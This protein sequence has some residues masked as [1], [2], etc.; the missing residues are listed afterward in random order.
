MTPDIL[1]Q[2]HVGNLSFSFKT[3]ESGAGI[4]EAISSIRKIMRTHGVE[5]ASLTSKAK[6]KDL[7][8]SPIA[9]PPLTLSEL[10]ISHELADGIAQNIRKVSYWN[11]VLTILYH[12]S[13]A[14][15]YDDIMSISGELRKPVS[16][17]WLNTE[18]QR[19]KYA[20]LVRSEPMPGSNKRKYS[21]TEPGR[22]RAEAFFR[23]VVPAP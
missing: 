17:D 12:T 22:R 8:A 21:I 1:I 6:E 10:K 4:D 14:L 18:F 11:L 16:Y 9:P 13:R 19:T 3:N 15:T 5:L 2:I 20:G 23:K 7:V